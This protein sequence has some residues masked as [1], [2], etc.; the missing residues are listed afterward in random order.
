MTDLKPL[1]EGKAFGVLMVLP[2]FGIV[3]LCVG[4]W[5]LSPAASLI[6]GGLFLL[7]QGGHAVSTVKKVSEE[8]LAEIEQERYLAEHPEAAAR[9]RAAGLPRRP[10]A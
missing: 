3:V 4:V 9:I 7:A 8:R 6:V 1:K 2:S 5:W 10:R